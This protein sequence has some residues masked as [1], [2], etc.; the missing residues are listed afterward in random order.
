MKRKQFILTIAIAAG[1]GG[2]IAYAANRNGVLPIF[3][4]SARSGA[5]IVVSRPQP[6]AGITSSQ[7]IVGRA[8]GPTASASEISDATLG[9]ADSF[10]RNVRWL[11][12]TTATVYAVTDCAYILAEDPEAL[13]QQIANVAATTSFAF[14][15]IARIQLP[16]KASNS[17]L[18]HW[19]SPRVDVD[20]VN[21]TAAPVPG[22]FRYN[23]TL[24]LENPVLDDP[25]LIDPTTGAPFG[26]KLTTGMAAAEFVQVM[27]EPRFPITQSLRDSVI[28][29]DGLISKRSLMRSYGLTES[30]AIKFFSK[31][32]M[33]RLNISGASRFV[34]FASLSLGLR[35]VGD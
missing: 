10:G 26:G 29:Q 8:G 1:L 4:S 5:S 14:K 30:Q 33:V 23:P 16:A 15:D 22:H 18:C 6:E 20:F 11:G 25:S 24:T 19:F 28:C 35:I 12:L 31:P 34:D 21:P 13:C 17:L 27:V 7:G 3:E 32:T 9:D 2:A